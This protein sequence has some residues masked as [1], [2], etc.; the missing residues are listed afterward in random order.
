[1]NGNITV[2]TGKY[3]VPYVPVEQLNEGLK[4]LV[5]RFVRANR[6][7]FGGIGGSYSAEAERIFAQILGV[8]VPDGGFVDSD[9]RN[10]RGVDVDGYGTDGYNRHGR[11][12]E[13]YDRHG[14]DVHGFRRD[15]TNNVGQTREQVAEAEVASWSPQHAAAVAAVLQ[16]RP[17]EA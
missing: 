15:G 14:F 11:D 5:D 12:R 17:V 16:R 7:G 6:E 9:G 1:M 4:W 8:T 10:Y 3:T 13:G 2:P